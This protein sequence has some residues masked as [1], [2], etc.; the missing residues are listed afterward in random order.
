MT[1]DEFAE[2]AESSEGQGAIQ[3]EYE[4]HQR[5]GTLKCGR[6]YDVLKQHERSRRLPPVHPGEILAETLA[7]PDLPGRGVR[8]LCPAR[9]SNR[10][11]HS[12]LARPTLRLSLARHFAAHFDTTPDYWMNMQA[13][14]NA[15]TAYDS[16]VSL[17][18][19]ASARSRYSRRASSSCSSTNTSRGGYPWFTPGCAQPRSRTSHSSNGSSLMRAATAR[20][21]PR[22]RD[23]S[24]VRTGTYSHSDTSLPR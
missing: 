12:S 5:A 22:H 18:P 11:R 10:E 20:V 17:S 19:V 1:D 14:Y 13:K 24:P 23:R 3:A 15:D 16:R 6:I 8:A 7:G 2:S 21:F 4:K 9:R